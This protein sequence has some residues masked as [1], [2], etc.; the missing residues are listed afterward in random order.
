MLEIQGKEIGQIKEGLAQRVLPTFA[1]YY[2]TKCVVQLGLFILPFIFTRSLVLFLSF[3][4]SLL[5]FFFFFF[6]PV[7]IATSMWLFGRTKLM[8]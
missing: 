4:V 6:L 7:N 8:D 3:Y 1:I 5:S 2:L